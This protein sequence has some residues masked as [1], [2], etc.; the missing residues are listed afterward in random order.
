LTASYF[1]FPPSAVRDD[2]LDTLPRAEHGFLQS[3]ND[4]EFW[5]IVRAVN[6]GSIENVVAT[7]ANI[8]RKIEEER[9]R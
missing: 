9:Q 6:G 3:L 2:L 7:W 4:A 5:V 1:S 8:R